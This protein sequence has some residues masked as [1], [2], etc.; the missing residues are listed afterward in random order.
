MPKRDLDRMRE[1]LLLAE[2]TEIQSWD[3][4]ETGYVDFQTELMPGDGYQL[5]QMRDAGW[6]EGED[7]NFGCFRIT[8]VGHE[9]LDAVRDQGIWKSTKEAIAETGGSAALEIV[10][11]LATGFMKKKIHQH[12]GFDL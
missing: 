7:A 6:I 4:D 5:V 12:T 2:A 9:Y 1:L 8:G 10:K 11:A 3:E